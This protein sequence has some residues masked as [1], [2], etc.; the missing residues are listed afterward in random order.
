MQLIQVIIP[1]I[2]AFTIT[3]GYYD[4][5]LILSVVIFIIFPMNYYTQQHL[6]SLRFPEIEELLPLCLKSVVPRKDIGAY[7]INI[8]VPKRTSLISKLINLRKSRLRTLKILKAH[9]MDHPDSLLE[10]EYLPEKNVFQGAAGQAY[11]E[12]SIVRVNLTEHT[13][14]DF[15]LRPEQIKCIWRSMKSICSIPIPHFE[16]RKILGVLTIDSS[17]EF[18]QTPLSDEKSDD[19]L[20]SFAS[21]LGKTLVKFL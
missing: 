18:D 6:Q 2:L 20:A 5:S 9:N 12:K 7:R 17:L 3:W 1:L 15:G 11:S 8:F 14:G 16:E 4:I 21:I 19:I 13:H 10:L